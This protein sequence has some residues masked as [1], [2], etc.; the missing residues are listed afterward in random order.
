[1]FRTSASEDV[2]LEAIA[3][4]AGVGVAT[5]YRNFPDR[6]SLQLACGAHVLV[7]VA[8]RARRARAEF[9]ENPSQAFDSFIRAVVAGGVGTLFPALA[10]S[11]LRQLPAEVVTEHTQLVREAAS[12]AD[13]AIEARLVPAN[14]TFYTVVA[15]LVV[16][17][18]T[19]PPSVREMDPHVTDRLIDDWLLAQRARARA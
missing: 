10:P 11:S 14:T 5:L 2:P 7:R 12:L 15:D 6:V 19:P 9:A 13:L 18:R 16:L 8:A 17:T 1:M 3:E 4:R